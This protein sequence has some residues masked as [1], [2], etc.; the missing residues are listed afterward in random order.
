VINRAADQAA[1]ASVNRFLLTPSPQPADSRAL[2]TGSCSN[3]PSMRAF[4]FA[5]LTDGQK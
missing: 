2:Q 1:G 4:P 3:P 5:V